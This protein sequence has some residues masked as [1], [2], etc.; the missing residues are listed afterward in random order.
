MHIES[1]YRS[2]YSGR[3]AGYRLY[4]NSRAM[5]GNHAASEKL[6]DMALTAIPGIPGQLPRA[7]ADDAIMLLSLTGWTK[8]S[9]RIWESSGGSCG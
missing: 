8:T 4:L 5:T 6:T 3:S 9:R 1:D 2:D 7:A